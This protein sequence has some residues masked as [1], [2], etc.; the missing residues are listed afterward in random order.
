MSTK[1]SWSRYAKEGIIE[2]DSEVLTML[3]EVVDT[4][5]LLERIYGHDKAQ[6]VVSGMIPTYQSLSSIAYS[7]NLENIPHL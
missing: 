2:S 1:H 6:L 7:R 4:I 3:Q 5:Q